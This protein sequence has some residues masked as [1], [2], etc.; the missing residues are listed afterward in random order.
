MA[1]IIHNTLELSAQIEGVLDQAANLFQNRIDQYSHTQPNPTNI[2]NKDTSTHVCTWDFKSRW[3][4]PLTLYAELKAI[5]GVSVE[6]T[7]TDEADHWDICYRWKGEG[8]K[9][10]VIEKGLTYPNGLTHSNHKHGLRLVTSPKDPELTKKEDTLRYPT[11]E[12]I[13]NLQLSSIKGECLVK[14]SERKPKLFFQIDCFGPD[15]AGDCVIDP[16]STGKGMMCLLT[17]ELMRGTP[18]RILIA[19]NYADHQLLADMLIEAAKLL[20]ECPEMLE[21]YQAKQ[22]EERLCDSVP[23]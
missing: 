19:D 20:R 4:A 7:W 8:G 3:A 17:W 18:L 23:F 5:E 22:R 11:N 2:F 16:S 6:A 10:E 12:F 15:A 9:Y 21:E 1:N 14:Y 13:S